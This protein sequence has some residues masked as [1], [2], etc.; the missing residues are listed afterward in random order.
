MTAIRLSL[1]RPGATAAEILTL[2]GN[3]ARCGLGVWIGDPL[4]GARHADDSYVTATA[5]ALATTTEHVRIGL[6]LSLRGSATTVRLAED[7]GVVDQMS[8]GRIDLGLVPPIEDVGAW[9]ELARGMLNSW[10]GWPM[11]DGRAPAVTPPPAQRFLPV[12]VLGDPALAEQLNGTFIS[13]GE[14]HYSSAARRCMMLSR[15]AIGDQGIEAWLAP[16][17]RSR[18]GELLATAEAASAQEIILVLEQPCITENDL[19]MLGSVVAIG[20]RA[21]AGD[22]DTLIEDAWNW[23]TKRREFHQ[24]PLSKQG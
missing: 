4:G 1:A 9:R 6:F 13:T 19:L 7:L 17:P 24:S 16:S 11:A 23:A 22:R 8:G 12:S 5:A 15:P 18:I 21:S 14:T 3:A 10:Q 2:A 20:L